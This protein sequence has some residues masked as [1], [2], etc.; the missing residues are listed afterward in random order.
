MKY[1]NT[2]KNAHCISS[3]SEF[4]VFSS[5]SNT[6][7][8][9]LPVCTKWLSE[10]VLNTSTCQPLYPVSSTEAS[11]SLCLR[12]PWTF[13]QILAPFQDLCELRFWLTWRHRRPALR[14][15][16]W[17]SGV[18][19]AL[20]CRRSSCAFLWGNSSCS[21]RSTQLPTLLMLRA[22]VSEIP[23]N[24]LFPMPELLWSGEMGQRHPPDWFHWEAP[25][26]PAASAWAAQ[27]RCVGMDILSKQDTQTFWP[28]I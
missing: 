9:Y 5:F 22:N 8:E 3:E 20:K 10:D 11:V 14:H 24:V 19:G 18:R 16:R 2:H 25:C 13:V 23:V 27:G 6:N 17:R 15:A 4:C 7:G 21:I 1:Q 28:Y 26:R 12:Q